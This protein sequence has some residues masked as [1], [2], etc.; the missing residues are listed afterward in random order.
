MKLSRCLLL[1]ALAATVLAF[2]AC[3]RTDAGKPRVAFVTN[4]AHDFWTIAQR[5]TEKAAKEFDVVCEFKMPGDG[6]AEAQRSIIEDLL[7]TGIKGIAVSPNA[8]ADSVGFYKKISAQV[9]LVTQDSDVPDPS[10]RRCYIGTNNYEAGKAAGELVKRAVPDGGQVIIYVGKLDAQNAVER[11]KG[12]L[13]ALAGQADAPG[14]P[15]GKFTKYGKYTVIGTMTDD[16]KSDKC[17]ANVED[18][19]STYPDVKCLVGLW[20]YNP[21]AML[22][23]VKRAK[24]EGKVAIVGF[25]E[26]EQTLQGIKDGHI[27]GTVVQDPFQFG[28]QAVKI[29]AGLAR[30]DES[31]L[32]E[33]DSQGR[34][35]VK[36]RVIDK[37]NVTAFQDELKK[38]KA[39]Q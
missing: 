24:M 35:Y 23:G 2:P 39:K 25:D 32:K 34:I 22:R 8:A 16:T 27:V 17:Q 12:V 13:D 5:G 28:Y 29:L 15:D 14:E 21:P 36:H 9:P 31:V 7:G 26:N 11:R 19:L 38:L 20:E 18:N 3:N 30:K 1:A 6:S 37:N 4:N 10:A 33:A